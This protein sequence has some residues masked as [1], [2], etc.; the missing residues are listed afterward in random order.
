[1]GAFKNAF[2]SDP[3]S[4]IGMGS[5]IISG[6]VG[7]VGGAVQGHKNRKL[8]RQLNA[9]N[10]AFQRETNAQNY[11]MW[12][13]QLQN[14]W[15][16]FHA[17]NAYNDP[18][19]ERQR[20]EAA[21]LNY[22]NLASG[23]SQATM[24]AT[25]A[26]TPMTAPQNDI[27]SVLAANS[28][29]TPGQNVSDALDS[30]GKA[31]QIFSLY[32]QTAIGNSKLPHEL[33]N[34]DTQT[35]HNEA[36]TEGQIINNQF[37]DQMNPLRLTSQSVAN[38]NA[39]EALATARLNNSML[40][41]KLEYLPENERNIARQIA[42]RTDTMAQTQLNE[43]ALSDLSVTE[44]IKSIQQLSANIKKTFGEIGVLGE[45]QRGKKLE[46]DF[47]E[48]TYEDRKDMVEANAFQEN[49]ESAY[50]SETHESRVNQQVNAYVSSVYDNML[51][52]FQLKPEG[53]TQTTYQMLGGYKGLK[54][55]CG[56]W[57]AAMKSSGAHNVPDPAVQAKLTGEWLRRNKGWS[58]RQVRIFE[59]LD[60]YQRNQ[61]LD[62]YWHI[63][64]TLGSATENAAKHGTTIYVT[65]KP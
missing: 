12:Q 62:T 25:P 20:A 19:A 4:A 59:G 9:D 30:I 24:P 13:E 16:M 42:I 47:N 11:Q 45:T 5:S 14:Q 40:G 39:K 6:I 64:G 50:R 18:S 49:E 58:R 34:M 1:M 48:D 60:E 57:S 17:T 31:M 22:A 56:E 53:M 27:S 3:F 46:N 29:F 36:L 10:L 63:P 38:Q 44:K 28:Q 65:R 52:D 55:L 15:D 7:G 23:Q 51:R 61:W 35:S 2:L 8:A 37:N 54:N 21:G 32:S 43:I 26:P 33:R 41:I